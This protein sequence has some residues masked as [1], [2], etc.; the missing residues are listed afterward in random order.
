MT[1]LRSVLAQAS[2][3]LLLLPGAQ[4]LRA[5]DSS[6]IRPGS[7][8]RIATTWPRTYIGTLARQDADSLWLTVAGAQGDVQTVVPLRSV[9]RMEVS[10]KRTSHAVRGTVI[11]AAAG[12]LVGTAVSVQCGSNGVN[13]FPVCNEGNNTDAW[14]G[15]ALGLMIGASSHTDHWAIV[16]LASQEP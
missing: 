6:V 4:Q 3:A 9:V 15:A 7:R 2:A 12:M 16:P 8:V 10:R 5:Q 13:I 14:I 11:G 1:S